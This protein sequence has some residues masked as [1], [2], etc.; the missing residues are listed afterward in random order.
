MQNATDTPFNPS[1]SVEVFLLDMDIFSP[2]TFSH[3]YLLSTN[4]HQAPFSH[5]QLPKMNPVSATLIELVH[6]SYV[7]TSAKRRNIKQ[8]QIQIQK[9]I[10]IPPGGGALFIY[11]MTHS[12]FRKAGV[13]RIF[14]RRC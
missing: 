3:K 8:T 6:S 10:Q 1:L 2:N 5:W 13:D 9:P 4:A 12:A 11:N 7:T 14:V